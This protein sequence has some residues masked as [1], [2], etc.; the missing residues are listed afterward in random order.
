MIWA[1]GRTVTNDDLSLFWYAAREWGRLHIRQPNFY[2]QTYG[3]TLEAI[4][5]EA[6]RRLGVPLWTATPLAMGAMA[7]LGWWLL[8][9]AAW[10]R[11]HRTLPLAAVAAPVV[12]SAY[13]AFYTTSGADLPGP[14]FIVVAGVALLIA[15]PGTIGEAAAW[16]LAGLGILLDPSAL[17]LAVP[18]AVWYLLSTRPL[19]PRAI[20]LGAVVPAAWLG[21]S[22][23][24]YRTHPD[25]DIHVS[26]AARPSLHQLADSAGRLDRFFTLY[27]P[28]LA[29]LWVLPL[30][31]LVALV[32]LLGSSRRVRYAIPAA[33]VPLLMLLAMASPKANDDLGPMLTPGR[34]LLVLPHTL[35]FLALLAAESGVLARFRVPHG[36]VV[37]VI[38]VTALASAGLRTADFDGRVVAQRERGVRAN[39]YYPFTRTSALRAE[40]RT[41]E[42]AAARAGTSL[43]VF[44]KDRTANY[45]CGALGYGRVDTLHTTYERRTWRLYE[46]LRT[47]R[48]AAVI[49][50]VPPGFC[51]RAGR[52]VD[53][54]TPVSAHA[55]VVGFRPQSVLTVLD[56]LR[57]PVRAFGPSCRPRRTPG[58]RIVCAHALRSRPER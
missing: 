7:L 47:T 49:A 15:G 39:V 34:L 13:H 57:L 28:E 38:V 11:S 5:T 12:L 10:R 44:T 45:A 4:P 6:F 18:V 56:D 40:C 9:A 37:A 1:A 25:Y 33:L 19:R 55:V 31:A 24:F 52:H 53:A 42:Q 14:R 29:R 27:V 17:L 41:L 36:A 58:Q 43:V 8:A 23:W 35:W 21:W 51:G 26:A 20:A 22:L 30:L 32:L 54:C 46:E 16:T 48:T 50:D 2:G 3:S